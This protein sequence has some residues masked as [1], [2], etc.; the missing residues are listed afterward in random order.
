MKKYWVEGVFVVAAVALVIW[1]FIQKGKTD[2]PAPQPEAEEVVVPE[3]VFKFGLPVDSFQIDA[4]TIKRN[5]NLSDILLPYGVS[6]QTIAEIAQKSKTIF[7]VRKIKQGNNYFFFCTPDSTSEAKYWIYEADPIEYVVFQLTDSLNIYKGEKPISRKIKT[8]SGVINSS[9]WNA[10]KDNDMNP[11]LAIE[12]SE[13]YAW[14]IDFFGIQKGDKFR[15]IYEEN[16]VDSIPVGINAIYAC[17]F[18]HQNEDFYAFQFEQDSITS[19]YDDQGKSLKKAFLKAPL[20]FSRISSRFSRSRLHPVLKIRRPHL[21]IDYAAPTGT[22]VQSIGDGVVT[23]KGYQARGGGNYV[24]IK[25]NSVYTT[26]YMH[27]HNFAKGIAPGVRIRQ[28]QVIGYVGKTGLAT[29]PH[30]DF[31]VFKNGSAMDP[32]KVK[33]PPVE[34]VKE[35]LMPQYTQLK[36]SLMTRLQAIPFGDEQPAT[37]QLHASLPDDQPAETPAK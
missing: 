8:A 29:G 35:A 20:K 36:D 32:L 34:P 12:L 2:T 27:L 5:Q 6:Y 26:C 24:Y 19:F 21:G 4:G 1:I 37:P 10:L 28:G 33:A 15:L 13:I 3:P 23:R 25:H 14:T 17:Q 11:V 9:L 31:R 18:Q 16:Y 22:P 7:D 30:L